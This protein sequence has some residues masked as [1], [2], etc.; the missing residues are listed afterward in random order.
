MDWKGDFENGHTSFHLIASVCLLL[1][2]MGAENGQMI[3]AAMGINS[4]R[5]ILRLLEYT[6]FGF[7]NIFAGAWYFPTVAVV[8]SL[9]LVW[10]ITAGRVRKSATFQSTHGD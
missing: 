6:P 1:A 9:L 7:L 8:L 5:L 10:S 4:I 3:V 2:A